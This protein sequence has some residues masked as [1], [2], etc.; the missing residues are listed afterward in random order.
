MKINIFR[1]MT[2][3]RLLRS[4]QRSKSGVLGL[5]GQWWCKQQNPP[6]RR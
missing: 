6:K 3:Y 1:D 2:Q 4:Q 5:L